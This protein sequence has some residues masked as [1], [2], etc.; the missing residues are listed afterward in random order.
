MAL[1]AV[2]EKNAAVAITP[3]SSRCLPDALT[4]NVPTRSRLL[5]WKKY[6]DQAQTEQLW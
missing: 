6:V 5:G 2:K 3:R 4:S 1:V